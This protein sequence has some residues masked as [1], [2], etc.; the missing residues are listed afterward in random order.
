MAVTLRPYAIRLDKKRRVLEIPWNDG[1]GSEY[2]WD[3]LRAACPCAG[4]RGG[5][6][7]MGAAPNATVFSLTP[8]QN[9]TL[10]RVE[11]SGN[12][13][14]QL[15]WSDGHNSGIYSWEYLREMQP[16]ES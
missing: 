1:Q 4:C 7:N 8:V 9:F 12:Y 5:H 3:V 2:T 11:L 10:D 16:P 15:H 6:E 13:A 14:L